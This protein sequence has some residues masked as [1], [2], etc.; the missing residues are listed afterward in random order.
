MPA[1]GLSFLSALVFVGAL[2]LLAN[3]PAAAFTLEQFQF[4]TPEQE[5]EFRDLIGKLRCLV[6]Q[7][8]S[9]E[10]SQ[11]GLAQDLREE[12]YAMMRQGQ[13]RTQII[14]FLTARYGDFVLYEPP[15]KPST[16]ILWFGPFVLIGVAGYFMVRA[17]LRSRTATP[18]GLSDSERDRLQ[19]LLASTPGTEDKP[20]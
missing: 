5:R 18:S 1:R 4:D 3:A 16:Y 14:E 13:S 17:L 6:C 2:A 10:G 9:L 15:L 20:E 12:V 19:R 7:N 11:A 8:E